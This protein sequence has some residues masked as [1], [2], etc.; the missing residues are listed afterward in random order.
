MRIVIIQRDS[1]TPITYTYFIDDPDTMKT[2]SDLVRTI[3]NL[4]STSKEKGV[5]GS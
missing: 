1:E 2:L 3:Q 4:S 5:E